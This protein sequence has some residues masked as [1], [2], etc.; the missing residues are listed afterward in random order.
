MNKKQILLGA[1]AVILGGLVVSPHF[2]EAYQGDPNVQGPNYTVQRHEAMTQAFENNDYNAWQEQMAG[3]GRV[4][5]VVNEDNFARFAEA[6]QLA[7]EGK[8]DEAREIRQE[9]GLGLKNGAGQG[10]RQGRGNGNCNR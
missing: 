4:T 2:V 5:E 6:H 8:H 10:Q 9:L 3:K 1:T 7:A